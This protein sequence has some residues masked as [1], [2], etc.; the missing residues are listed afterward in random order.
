M[1]VTVVAAVGETKPVFG[2]RRSVDPLRLPDRGQRRRLAKVLA[3][4][5]LTLTG[6]GLQ[7]AG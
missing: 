7:R 3:G 6:G 5:R 1:R 2:R 4:T